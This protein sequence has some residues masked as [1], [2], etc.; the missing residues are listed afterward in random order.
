MQAGFPHGPLL[1]SRDGCRLQH[2]SPVLITNALSLHLVP[3]SN[4]LAHFFFHS[5]RY[6]QANPTIFHQN[7]GDPLSPSLVLSNSPPI[8]Y[9]RPTP[10][11]YKSAGSSWTSP[12]IRTTPT[13]GIGSS[14]TRRCPTET[15]PRSVLHSNP[16]MPRFLLI[17]LSHSHQPRSTSCIRH[18]VSPP[19]TPATRP[20]SLVRFASPFAPHPDRPLPSCASTPWRS[21]PQ[22]IL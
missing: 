22:M 1:H 13:R 5:T 6:L 14:T 21:L 15:R 3:E 8:C 10:Y 18:R 20:V 4:Q 19:C 7:E 16:A 11:H 12:F 17:T 9:S 2:Y